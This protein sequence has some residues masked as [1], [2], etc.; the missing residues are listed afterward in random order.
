MGDVG[1]SQPRQELALGEETR[2][3]L[4]GVHVAMEQLQR[5]LLVE[6]PVHPLGQVDRPH[7]AVADGCEGPVGTDPDSRLGGAFDHKSCGRGDV[8]RQAIEEVRCHALK[9]EQLLHLPA[10][11]GIVPTGEVEIGAPVL[12]WQLERLAEQLLQPFQ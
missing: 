1:V 5:H 6:G 10:Q 3:Q 2:P 9:T 4:R 7:A 12:G 8:A 11:I